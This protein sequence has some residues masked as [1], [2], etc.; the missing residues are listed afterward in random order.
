MLER[1]QKRLFKN[2]GH[3]TQL[4]GSQFPDQGSNLGH[5]S[6]SAESYPLDREL[7]TKDLKLRKGLLFYE[8]EIESVSPS[9]VSSS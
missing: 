2:F 5:N 6:K 9:V 1:A 4:V 8:P 3:A 7:G